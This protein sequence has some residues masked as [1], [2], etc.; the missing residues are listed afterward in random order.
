MVKLLKSTIFIETSKSEALVTE[1]AKENSTQTQLHT[2]EAETD[3]GNDILPFIRN[4][5]S[6][7]QTP[8]NEMNIVDL[9]VNSV[10]L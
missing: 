9:K 7:V 1:K 6:G 10:S 3:M 2:K 8:V 5:I 4:Y